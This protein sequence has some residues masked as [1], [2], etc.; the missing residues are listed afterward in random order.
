MIDDDMLSRRTGGDYAN[1]RAKL[2]AHF[3]LGL[4][5]TRDRGSRGGPVS[6]LSHWPAV[7]IA[8]GVVYLLIT[9]RNMPQ[10][11][12]LL[13]DSSALRV[14]QNQTSRK[15]MSP[16]ISLQSVASRDSRVQKNRARGDKRPQAGR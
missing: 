5:R 14:L 9:P 10:P 3:R 7:A 2:P 6:G 8:I 13:I 15:G 16:S 11:R 4:D 12:R 1:V